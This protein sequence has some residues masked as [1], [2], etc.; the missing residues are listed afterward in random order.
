MHNKHADA[1]LSHI[2]AVI[3][4]QGID[5]ISVVGADLHGYPRGKKVSAQA[6]CAQP[7]NPMTLS[8]LFTML[9]C[10]NYPIEPPADSEFWW[11]AWANGYPDSKAIVD[12]KTFRRVP[13]QENTALVLCDFESFNAQYSLDF[14]PRRMLQKLVG[15]CHEL[16]FE[17]RVGIEIET[18]LFHQP[19]KADGHKHYQSLIPLWGGLE[20]YLLTTLGKHHEALDYCIS[21]LT[22]FGLTL[23]CWHCE[24][25]P[26]QLEAT[27]APK[28]AVEAADAAFLF[29]HG[30]KELAANKD[31][32]ASFMSQ[33]FSDGFA[34]G[35]HANVSLWDGSQ[36][37]FYDETFPH[38]VSSV[39]R[40][41]AAGMLDTLNE[42]S[43]LFSPTPNSR[44]R[45]RP[46]HWTGTEIAWGLDNKSTALRA[47]MHSEQST[48]IEH[49]APAADANPYLVI[50]AC[51]AGMLH[52]IENKLDAPALVTADAYAEL[53]VNPLDDDYEH[54]INRFADSEIAERYFGQDFVRFYTHSRKA[55]WALFQANVAATLG[56]EVSE[57]EFRRYFEQ[58]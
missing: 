38:N 52:G 22:A 12:P 46:Y 41:A 5:T 51:L 7:Q 44:R 19:D 18:S 24:A 55:E 34:N 27:L 57:W 53:A 14:L 39:M 4:D 43:I 42:F 13:W 23:E 25:G 20:A 16:G 40:Q 2:T 33:I 29:K 3:A 30:I 1:A 8:T 6:F 9:D 10:G 48:R 58:A 32:V 50:A 31:L 17:T 11:P 15:R 49:R 36:N 35:A 47:V 21:N 56:N 26:G 45:Y 37:V 54:S 28:P